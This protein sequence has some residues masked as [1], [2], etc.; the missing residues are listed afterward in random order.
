MTRKLTIAIIASMAVMLATTTTYAF[1]LPD[2][3]DEP[4]P[5][6]ESIVQEVCMAAN[7][8]HVLLHSSAVRINSVNSTQQQLLID[9][10]DLTARMLVEEAERTHIIS[11]SGGNGNGLAVESGKLLGVS[12]P[13]SNINQ[14]CFDITEQMIPIN[15]TINNLYVETDTIRANDYAFTLYKNQNATS[16]TCT[17]LKNS[18]TTCGDLTHSITVVQGD[19][20]TFGNTVTLQNGAEFGRVHASVALRP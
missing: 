13:C 2:G 4:C 16:I 1:E 3:F 12:N 15:G 9:V 6:G 7:D 11:F 17:I 8:L 19:S 20:I 5:M 10:A 18:T 14:I